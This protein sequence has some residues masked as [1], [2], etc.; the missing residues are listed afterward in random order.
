MR[1]L[2]ATL[3]VG[4][5]ELVAAS[6]DLDVFCSSTA[7]ALSACEAYSPRGEV[8][9]RA[10][11]DAAVGLVRTPLD[12]GGH[13]LSGLDMVWGFASPVVGPEL[14][15]GAHLVGEALA[16]HRWSVAA[17]TGLDPDSRRYVTLVRELAP[18]YDLRRGP[19]MT[20]CRIELG[21]DGAEGVL[22]RRSSSFRR[23]FRQAQRRADAAGLSIELVRGG[24]EEIIKRCRVVDQRSWKGQ[25]GV[26]LVEDTM[27]S[28]YAAMAR[29]FEP[30]GGLRAGFAQ[31]DGVDVGYILGAVL[32]D[33][34]RGFQLS[35]D[36]AHT[37]L[38]IGNLL[39]YAQLRALEA[40]PVTLYD[41]GMDMAYK[42]RWADT[43]F[44]T[45]A[46]I[47]LRK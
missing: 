27:F 28:F 7:W 9:G 37:R 36:V 13:L 11:S 15:V 6:P 47:V 42:R 34:Y 32:Q 4:W 30:S 33:T 14:A 26:G 24:G 40:E 45:E 22:G 44:T 35:Y 12:D 20:R 2:Q 38:S 21:D 19:A 10:E 39:Q 46:L 31:I 41:L 16:R 5:D 1:W 29:R 23:T 25:Q 17:L 18:H 3:P 43:T 8:V